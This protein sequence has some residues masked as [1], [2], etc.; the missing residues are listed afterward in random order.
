MY[1]RLDK[2]V[3]RIGRNNFDKLITVLSSAKAV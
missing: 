3:K 2:I 1:P